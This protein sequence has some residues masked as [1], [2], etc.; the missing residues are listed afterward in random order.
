MLLSGIG[1]L[2]TVFARPPHKEVNRSCDLQIANRNKAST[3]PNMRRLSAL[4]DRLPFRTCWRRYQHLVD[5]DGMS[6]IPTTECMKD[7]SRRV[8]EVWEEEIAPVVRSGKRV[9]VVVRKRL[10]LLS[11]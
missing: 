6:T 7:V 9:M 5:A 8:V 1:W 11:D 3:R 10:G 4:F 2:M